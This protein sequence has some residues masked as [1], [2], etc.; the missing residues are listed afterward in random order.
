VGPDWYG[1]KA[2]LGEEGKDLWIAFS[3]SGKK[4]GKSGKSDTAERT[5]Q[6]FKPDHISFGTL[7]YLAT[8]NG[9]EP[10]PDLQFSPDDGIDL[11]ALFPKA[12]VS[13]CVDVSWLDRL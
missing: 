9:W 4:S 2:A 7:Y 13:A 11:S 12:A 3:K 6:S 5:G 10:P 8:E 1:H